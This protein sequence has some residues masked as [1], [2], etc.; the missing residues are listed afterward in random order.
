MHSVGNLR[1]RIFSSFLIIAWI[2]ASGQ[3]AT[4]CFVYCYFCQIFYYKLA[5]VDMHVQHLSSLIAMF[6]G[7]T[8][9]CE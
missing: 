3:E 1:E 2:W 5:N 8:A 4:L 7:S 9:E 6:R